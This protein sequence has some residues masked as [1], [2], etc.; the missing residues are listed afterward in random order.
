MTSP[1]TTD[2]PGE[3]LK[4]T[5]PV[6][7]A[8]AGGFQRTDIIILSTDEPDVVAEWR[9]LTTA[10]LLVVSSLRHESAARHVAMLDAPERAS[11]HRIGESRCGR[12]SST[13]AKDRY[14][15]PLC[16]DT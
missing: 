16:G 11:S 5:I 2:D 14:P 12:R 1:G 13:R 6:T 9:R 7:I 15:R 3:P 10:T 8:T 4:L